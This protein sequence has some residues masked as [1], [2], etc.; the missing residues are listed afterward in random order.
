MTHLTVLWDVEDSSNLLLQACRQSARV[1]HA[2]HHLP[3]D[4]P[5]GGLLL[6]QQLVFL[7]YRPA[8]V[9]PLVEPSLG[10]GGAHCD[11]LAHLV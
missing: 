2:L 4:S 5:E 10:W 9:P 11:L 3:V 6:Q 1:L 7:T 8:D